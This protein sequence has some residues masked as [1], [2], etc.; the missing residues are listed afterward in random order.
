MLFF[1]S[2]FW[3]SDIHSFLEAIFEILNCIT[4]FHV[5]NEIVYIYYMCACV[6]VCGLKGLS[7]DVTMLKH[8]C[9][10]GSNSVHPENGSRLQSI[11]ARFQEAGLVSRCQVRRS[12]I[13]MCCSVEVNFYNYR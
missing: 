10:C 11:W 7:Y 12:F 2:V 6:C 5:D 4:I 9:L 8:Q 13:Y 1:F 3:P